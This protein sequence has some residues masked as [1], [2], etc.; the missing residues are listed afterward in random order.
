MTSSGGPAEWLADAVIYHIYPQSFSDSDSDGIG[1]LRGIEERLDYLAWLGLD[2]VWLSPVFTSPFR[3]AGYDVMD[4]R[5]IASRYSAVDDL[6]SLVDAAR[7]RGMRILLDLVAGH[8]SDEHPWFIAAANDPDDDCSQCTLPS[9]GANRRR[10]RA[11]SGSIL[12]SP[13][14]ARGKISADSHCA[15]RTLVAVPVLTP[16]ARSSSS[17]RWASNR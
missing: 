11:C 9:G 15:A 13:L 14:P 1:D 5:A 12:S 16:R 7:Q 6:V 17:S 10:M 2:V 8:T 4:Y 3:D